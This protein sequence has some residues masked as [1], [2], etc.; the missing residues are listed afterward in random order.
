MRKKLGGWLDEGW[1]VGWWYYAVAKRA[2]LN[3]DF[4]GA[5]SHQK[6][7]DYQFRRKVEEEKRHAT[8]HISKIIAER[9]FVTGRR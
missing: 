7:G 5:Q 1:N 6:P 2:V 3:G 8:K 9:N 4:H